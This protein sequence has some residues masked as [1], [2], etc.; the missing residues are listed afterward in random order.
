M[1]VMC[2]YMFVWWVGEARGRRDV[3]VG[4]GWVWKGGGRGVKK[5]GE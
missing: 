3:G 4:V 5:R 1:Y 2:I